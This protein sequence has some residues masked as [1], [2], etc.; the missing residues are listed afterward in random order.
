MDCG[1]DAGDQVGKPGGG[2]EIQGEE[3]T[4]TAMPSANDHPCQGTTLPKEKANTKLSLIWFC[5]T[6][7]LDLK[8]SIK[9]I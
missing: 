1:V 2:E 5:S 7:T 9:V 8:G 3:S 6:G 4:D